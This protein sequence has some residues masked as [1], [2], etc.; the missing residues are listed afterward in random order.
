MVVAQSLRHGRRTH[1]GLE[2]VT[3]QVALHLD[4][5]PRRGP[6]T[7]VRDL[8]K[9]PANMR[10]PRHLGDRLPAGS[11]RLGDRRRQIFR[12]RLVVDAQTLGELALGP[13]R[14]PMGETIRS[15]RSFSSPS[16][17]FLTSRSV[18]RANLCARPT[19]GCHTAPGGG[20]T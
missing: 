9:P 1:L 18:S 6:Q 10:R 19:G 5:L 11:Q 3:D 2:S 13:T 12:D 15:G 17:R 16:A 7:R 4:T 20:I 14:M 8:G